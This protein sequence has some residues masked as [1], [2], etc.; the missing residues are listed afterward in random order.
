[1]KKVFIWLFLFAGF[2]LTA[3]CSQSYLTTS[4]NSMGVNQQ[5]DTIMVVAKSRS[6]ALRIGF[7]KKIV[8][9][10]AMHGVNAVTSEG[11]VPNSM[12]ERIPDEARL[13]ELR[14]ELLSKGI[15]GVLITTLVDQ[16]EYTEV[17]PG[18]VSPY[19]YYRGGY[20]RYW[21]HYPMNYWEPD[22]IISGVNYYLESALYDISLH[23]PD[24]MHWVGS[25]RLK[26]PGAVDTWSGKYA[27]DL[28]NALVDENSGAIV[29]SQ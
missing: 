2:A 29:A 6:Q 24:N 28:V 22:R 19:P 10:L 21:R 15:D 11:L 9:Q 13:E 14:L 26:N 5:Y 7:E 20:N 12:F 4:Q 1:M 16:Q 25:F 18:S 3:G 23:S 17:I 27:A 8:E